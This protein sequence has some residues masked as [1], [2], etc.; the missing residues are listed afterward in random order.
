MFITKMRRK[1]AAI[2]SKGIICRLGGL[3]NRLRLTLTYDNGS[4]N[5]DHLEVNRILGMKSYFCEPYHSWEKGTVENSIGL[6]RRYFPKRTDFS[7][8]SHD[9]I[10]RVEAALNDRPR[11]CLD[12]ST[13]R[14][15]LSGALT[16]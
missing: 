14:E 7:L 11:K 3:P 1:T 12:Y 2:M 13:P 9:S 5:A 4:E 8:I 16:G 10:M 15:A 6:I